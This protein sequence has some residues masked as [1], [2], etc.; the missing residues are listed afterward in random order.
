[1]F[2]MDL[3][4]AVPVKKEIRDGIRKRVEEYFVQNP[5]MP[6]VSYNALWEL[7]GSLIARFG[8][9]PEHKAFVMVCCGNAIWRTV[10]ASVP[11]NRRMLL[12][13]QCLR[14]STSC[15]AHEDGL[16]LLCAECGNCTIPD[17]IN[18][19]ESLGYLTLVSEGTTIASRMVEDGKVDAIIGVGCMEVLQKMFSAVTKYSV[20]AIGIPLLTDGCV[21]TTADSSW[22]M[23]EINYIDRTNGL[24]M[25]N[26][27]NLQQKTGKLFTKSNITGLL[28]LKG[29]ATGNLALD[30][31]LAG[32]KRIRPLLAIL[33]YEA[34]S[35][36]PDAGV[37]DRLALSVECFHKASLIHDDI[38]DKESSRYG[39]ETVHTRYDEAVAINLGDYLTGSGYSLIASSGLPPEMIRNCLRVVSDGHKYLSEG[40]GAELM[41]R[42][43]GEI[44]SLEDILKVFEN[45]T[46]A[47]FKVALLLGAYAAGADAESIQLLEEYSYNIG[48]AYQLKDDLDDFNIDNES[49]TFEN[50][51]VI[52]SALNDRLDEQDRS[53]FESALER[54]DFVS[55][56]KLVEKYKITGM[57]I[58]MMKDYLDDLDICIGKI[59][60]IRLKLTLN[61]IV[62]KTFKDYL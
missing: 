26:L 31:L 52:I 36:E 49:V 7:A 29:T 16:G 14:S 34:L 28:D 24:S 39:G 46:A 51:S 19:A 17:F 11:F 53:I 2:K 5:L 6:P 15:R 20:P 37:A 47:A 50:T 42:R 8:W 4:L 61:E 57:V 56:Q 1:M 45:K 38:E 33:T 60:N 59:K 30:A 3:L 40:Q 23:E 43:N 12:L 35:P 25:L 62:G 32:G 54:N 27:K 58:K 18:E 55:I 44:F 48:L 22:I 21:N 10:V 9:E 41:A 13:P